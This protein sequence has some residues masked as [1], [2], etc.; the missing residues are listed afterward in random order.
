MQ[1]Q[2]TQRLNLLKWNFQQFYRQNPTLFYLMLLSFALLLVAKENLFTIIYLVY[3]TYFGGFLLRQFMGLQSLN[4]TYWSTGAAGVFTAMMYHGVETPIS[5]V[6][7]AFAGAAAL[8]LL[9][10]VAFKNPEIKMQLMFF[11]GSQLKWVAAI[12]VGLDLIG[13][14][15]PRLAQTLP[16]LGGVVVALLLALWWKKGTFN[17]KP[18]FKSYSNP[19]PP[20]RPETDQQYHERKQA[21]QAQL[22]SVLDKIKR[23]GYESLSSEEK[24]KL[25]DQSKND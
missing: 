5:T 13:L 21:Q 3:L 20:S 4:I 22:D 19:N 9:T 15:G 18:K 11:G 24:K 17:H 7:S 23:N 12:L 14:M 1:N 6:L 25:F 8:G 16:H 10:A 2:F